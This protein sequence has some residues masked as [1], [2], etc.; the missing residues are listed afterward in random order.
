M[1]EVFMEFW[2]KWYPV[3]LLVGG[4][5]FTVGGIVLSAYLLVKP[6]IDWFKDK[7]NELKENTTTNGVKEDITNKLKA[8]DVDVKIAELQD[9]INNPLTSEGSR[10]I[11][12]QSLQVYTE[13]KIKLENGIAI[14]DSAED[15]TNKYL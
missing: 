11:Y 1:T 15:T 9:K 14:V 13:I 6:K 8:V 7:L 4:G 5:I 2:D 3:V 10:K 12:S